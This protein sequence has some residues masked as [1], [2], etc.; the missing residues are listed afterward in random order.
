MAYDDD[1]VSRIRIQATD[2]TGDVM[3]GMSQRIQEATSAFAKLGTGLLSAEGIRRSVVGFAELQR[4][5]E[6]LQFATQASDKQMA[7]LGKTFDEVAKNTGRST[8]EI[9]KAFQEFY[10]LTGQ[11]YGPALEKMFKTIGEASAVTGTSLESLSRIA[12]AAVNNMKVPQEQMDLLIKKL[13][14]DLP[15]SLD[16]F[17][18]VA[19]RVTEELNAIGLTG[20]KNAE[21][22]ALAFSTL[23]RAFGNTRLTATALNEVFGAMVDGSSQFGKMMT[24][25]LLE[26]R[27]HGGDVNETFE[28]M[29]KKLEA[30]GAF[31]PNNPP[32]LLKVMGLDFN[33]VKAIKALHDGLDATKQKL[34]ESGDAAGK[35]GAQFKKT[36]EDGKAAI[37]HLVASVETLTLRIGLLLEKAGSTSL[38]KKFTDEAESFARVLEEVSKGHYGK[39]FDEATRDVGASGLLFRPHIGP[40]ARHGMPD[41]DAPAPTMPPDA[42]WYSDQSL[43]HRFFGPKGESTTPPK[44]AEGGIVTKPTIAEIG[45]KGPE[46]VVPLDGKGTE[47]THRDLEA[48]RLEIDRLIEKLDAKENVDATKENTA[49]VNRMSGYMRST[50]QR[51]IYGNAAYTPGAGESPTAAEAGIYGGSTGPYQG[52]Y[53]SRSSGGGGSGPT[54]GH[55]GVGGH[56]GLPSSDSDMDAKDKAWWGHGSR[57]H[58]GAGGET[59][60]GTGGHGGVLPKNKRDV[61]AI[62]TDE[63]RKAGMS[64]AGIAGIMANVQDESQFNPT[65]RHPDQPHFGGEAHFAHGLYQEGGTEWN[66]YSAWLNKNYPGA[67]W[68]DPRLQ[69]RFAAQRLKTGYG[70]TWNRMKNAGSGGEAASAYVGGYLKPAANFLAGRQQKYSHGV[71]GVE[72]YTGGHTA[73][74]SDADVPRSTVGSA[75]RDP[76]GAGGSFEHYQ[77]MR[78]HLERP[79]KMNIEAPQPPPLYSF[80]QRM[81]RQQSRYQSDD[82]LGGPRYASQ[83]DIGFA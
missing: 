46:A 83:I 54:V 69:S 7:G 66:N 20:A 24:P 12:G 53:G 67:D 52:G 25:T 76:T 60:A 47:S 48:L 29:Y 64:E 63:W 80:R 56:G 40:G 14:V 16:A 34:A 5:M 2:E 27:K 50:G 1:I 21:E 65:L 32:S 44:M 82:L 3:R 58:G 36:N 41:A 61:A 23:N 22:I 13:A 42:P 70:P 75:D 78:Q 8:D 37:D 17:S 35:F 39:A 28:T 15:G 26:I 72:H 10:L 11:T 79:I 51:G 4:S 30:M 68:Q 77:K 38:L 74:E 81:A 33:T 43:M 19:P 57:S 55:G 31:N 45:E 49:A 59:P 62:M 71:P 73:S 6:K 9:V 18:N